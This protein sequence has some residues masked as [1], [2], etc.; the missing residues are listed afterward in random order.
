[1][2]HVFRFPVVKL[3]DYEDRREELEASTNPF[4]LVVLAH[5]EARKAAT[6]GE[7][8]D[9]KFRLARRLYNRGFEGEDIRRLYRF[10][11]W[12]L[13]LPDELEFELLDRIQGEI[14]GKAAMPY[15]AKYERIAMQRGR[16]EGLREAVRLQLELRF[17]QAGVELAS[18]VDEIKDVVR[19]RSLLESLIKDS[20]LGV[21][22]GL[23]ETT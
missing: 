7:R 1:M 22:K 13:D 10:I 4:S 19:L 18:K 15:L 16:E 8:F 14:Q 17:G 9:A 12:I 21:F 5:L 20:D 11:D 6:V 3:L 23:L 2:V